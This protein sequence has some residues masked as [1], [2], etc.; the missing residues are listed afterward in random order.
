M[1]WI[2]GFIFFVFVVPN[3]TNVKERRAFSDE[4][5]LDIA[6]AMY[7]TGQTGDSVTVVPG[8]Y[9]DRSD[10]ALIFLGEKHR[11][12]WTTPV[13]ANVFNYD[14]TNGGLKPVEF[15]GGQQTISIKL[16]DNEGKKWAL[17]SVNKDQQSV[18][19]GF[20][21]VTF[22]RFLVRDQLASANPYA[23]LV[24]P[25]LASAIGIRHT[26][27]QLVMVPYDG[28][29]DKYNERMAG[30]LAYLEED[31]NTSWKNTKRFGSASDIV[32]TE[33]MKEIQREGIIPV[34]TMLYLR[35]RL[36]D[37]LISD[38]DRHEG[39]WE[40]ALTGGDEG[41]VFEPIPKDRDNAFYRFD[42]GLFSHIVLLFTPKFQ[43]FRKDY[44]KI[45]GLMHQS[46]TMDRQMLS[47]VDKEDFNRVAE[48]IRRTLTDEVI[49]LAFT[50]Y[51][52]EI[53]HI[54][55]AEH[56][57]ILEARLKKLPQVAEKFYDLLHR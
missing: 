52:P 27:P 39:N 28:R 22:L 34:D 29:F 12:L 10:V 13:R 45:R 32:N 57:Q 51:P 15:G 21:R 53:Q 8:A 40:W 18:L 55:A 1:Y 23:Q 33:E 38:W 7:A 31:L 30:R 48:E 11:K 20:L 19:P 56:R 49:T 25:V 17:R 36:F 3:T 14:K 43:S 16:E 2:G 5:R 6:Q 9:Y 47:S 4:R 42:E 35:T 37:M 24:L 26:T 50:R 44:G 46:K 54:A 41:K